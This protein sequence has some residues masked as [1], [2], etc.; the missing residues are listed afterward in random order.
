[1][2]VI[3]T[4]LHHHYSPARLEQVMAEMAHR[5]GPRVRAYYDAGYRIWFA[6]EG[7]HRLRAAFL[8]GTAP[9]LLSS[10]WPRSQDAL[11]RA[12]FAASWRGYVFE[13]VIVEESHAA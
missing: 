9:V 10:A 7:T 1:M 5:G 4:A 3:V 13:R 2:S 6:L 12:R 8:L 11:V